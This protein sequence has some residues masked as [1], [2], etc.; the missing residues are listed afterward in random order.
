MSAARKRSTYHAAERGVVGL[1]KSAALQYATRGIRVNSVCPG[2][3]QTPM[4][5]TI[6]AE[7]QGEILDTML[8][9]LVPVG[10]WQSRRDRRR[11]PMAVQ[12]RRYVPDNRSLATA[13]M[14]CAGRHKLGKSAPQ[15]HPS[16]KRRH[17]P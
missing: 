11:R 6:S 13:A 5:D 7:G 16:R 14:S 3:I 2:M 12:L 8:K 9:V 10:A 4:T 1:T 15:Q 17:P